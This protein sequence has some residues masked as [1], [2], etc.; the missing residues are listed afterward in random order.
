M[1]SNIRMTQVVKA[2][3]ENGL[4][5][6][7]NDQL[8]KLLSILNPRELDKLLMDSLII[9]DSVELYNRIDEVRPLVDSYNN[10]ELY[11]ISNS[12]AFRGY[13]HSLK[14]GN[15]KDYLKR[16]SIQEL[17]DLKKYCTL[18]AT[19]EVLSQTA[20]KKIISLITREIAFKESKKNLTFM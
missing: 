11:R 17:A 13:L 2:I 16:L 6:F 18:T 4:D 19:D 20:T 9:Y 5:A 8:A 1:N 14:I 10:R 3:T 7:E 15:Y 12:S